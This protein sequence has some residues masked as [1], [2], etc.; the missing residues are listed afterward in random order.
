MATPVKTKQGILPLYLPE[1]IVTAHTV[2]VLFFSSGLIY[3][4]G[5]LPC[6]NGERRKMWLWKSIS[7]HEIEGELQDST[8]TGFSLCKH[9]WRSTRW[10]PSRSCFHQCETQ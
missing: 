10:R 8:S 6:W 3:L 1:D 5:A 4:Y 9:G 2:P 7:K